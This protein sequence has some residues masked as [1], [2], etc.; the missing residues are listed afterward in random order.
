MIFLKQ[1]LYRK[2]FAK[3]TP[4]SSLKSVRAKKRDMGWKEGVPNT[5]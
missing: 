3:N 5:A 1:L 4:F 2:F